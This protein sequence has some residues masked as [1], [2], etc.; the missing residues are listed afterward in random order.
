MYYFTYI[1]S[2][3]ILIFHFNRDA[4][5]QKCY[6]G[7]PKCRGYIGKK[8]KAGDQSS[9]DESDDNEDIATT[10]P[11]EPAKKKKLYM[12]KKITNK[13]KKRLRE[14]SFINKYIYKLILIF[15]FYNFI[16]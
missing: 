13:D 5:Q 10:K 12:I 1:H 2:R 11:D 3:F 7:T 9:S 15:V 16:A 8:S 14:V 4:A 6:C